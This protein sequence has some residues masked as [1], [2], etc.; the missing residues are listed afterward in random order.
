MTVD[1]EMKI[2]GT[3]VDLMAL[4]RDPGITVCLMAPPEIQTEAIQVIYRQSDSQGIMIEND[5]NTIFRRLITVLLT[6][7]EVCP[8]QEVV[9]RPQVVVVVRLQE[10]VAQAGVTILTEAILQEM[11]KPIHAEEKKEIP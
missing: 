3:Q 1:P 6:I 4:L 2:M 5:K 9:V 10:A 11:T 8:Q 7:A